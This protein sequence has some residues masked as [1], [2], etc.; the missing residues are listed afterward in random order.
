MAT[1]TIALLEQRLAEL[2]DEIA[3]LAEERDRTERALAGARG[4]TSVEQSGKRLDMISQVRVRHSQGHQKKARAKGKTSRVVEIANA[5]GYSLHMLGEQPGVECT[6]SMLSQAA[7]GVCGMSMERAL[8]IQAL[9]VSETFPAGIEATKEF[10]PV[11]R[12]AK[13]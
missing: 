13:V 8:R 5:A 3:R 2:D 11:L 7:S 10:W 1:D 6:A 12:S 4:L 9:T